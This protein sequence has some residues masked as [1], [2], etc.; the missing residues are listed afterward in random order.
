MNTYVWIE[1]LHV[2]AAF[3]F[4]AG[5]VS[6]SLFLSVVGSSGPPPQLI[7]L[8]RRWDRRFVQPAMLLT[9]GLGILT[10]SSG[11]WFGRGWL[12]IKI[13]V[14]LLLSAVHGFQAARLRRLA[15]GIAPSTAQWIIPAL[16]ALL[17]AIVVLVIA[18]P[19]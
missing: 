1:V 4:F 11:G 10:A 5:V 13:G 19:L 2:T 9:W 8:V 18:K 15:E 14:V 3:V 16:L 7:Y 6:V 17:L 12:S